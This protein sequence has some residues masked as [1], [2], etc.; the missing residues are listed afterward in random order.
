MPSGSGVRNYSNVFPATTVVGSIPASTPGASEVYTLNSVAGLPVAPFTSA[1]NRGQ[2]DEEAVLVTAVNVG[3]KA[4]TVSRGYDGTPAS[5]HSNATQ[6]VAFEHVVVALDW[7][8]ANAHVNDASVSHAHGVVVAG[9]IATGLGLVASGAVTMFAGAAAPSGWLLCD[10]TA[11]SRT[12]FAALFAAI[13]TTFGIGDGSTTF[14]LPNLQGRV[15]VGLD[16][17]Q[18]EFDVL[19]ETGGE[20][21]HALTLAE[22]AAHNHSTPTGATTVSHT[23]TVGYQYQT[24]ASTAGT[25]IRVSD[26]NNQ[27]GGTGTSATATTSVPVASTSHTHS[28]ATEGSG[29]PH[30]NLQP[31]IALNYIIK[32]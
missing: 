17:G 25:G 8:E 18:T 26:I 16:A 5:A 20:K 9:D 19:G 21:T 11:V 2:N 24:D 31:Y 27:T 15:P 7:R 22:M 1:F 3:T 13:G 30:N 14:N 6:A 28:I 12:T 29:T 32:T 4:V 10:G 23:H